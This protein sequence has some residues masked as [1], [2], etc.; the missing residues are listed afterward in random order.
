MAE[1]NKI[2]IEDIRSRAEKSTSSVQDCLDLLDYIDTLTDDIDTHGSL[3]Q[4]IIDNISQY[5][6]VDLNVTIDKP[7][8][9]KFLKVTQ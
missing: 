9:K 4:R 5:V 8:L 7:A 1:L 2:Q 6:D 3:T